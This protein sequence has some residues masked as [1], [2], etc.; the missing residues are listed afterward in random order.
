MPRIFHRLT[1]CIHRSKPPKLFPINPSIELFKLSRFE[2]MCDEIL[3]EIFEYFSIKDLYNSFVHLNFRLNLLLRDVHLGINF[4]DNDQFDIKSVNYFRKE[5][6]YLH[7]D[8]NPMINLNCFNNLR[9]LSIYLPTRNQLLAI[10]N[11]IMPK[12]TRLWIGIIQSND[13]KILY[14]NFFGENCLGK[15]RFCYLFQMNF[16]QDF[17]SFSISSNIRRLIISNIQ[18]KDILSILS[19]FPSLYQ[20]SIGINDQNEFSTNNL[21]KNLHRNLRILKIEFLENISSLNDLKILLSFVPYVEQ[22]TLL[23]VNL[24]QRKDYLFLQNII[25]EN[26]IQLKQFICSIDYQCHFSSNHMIRKFQRF[27]LKFPFFHTMRIIPCIIHQ[28]KCLRKTFMNK[29]FHSIPV[30]N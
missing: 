25:L 1:S 11:R 9:S 27:I 19:F 23:F 30:D 26:F 4:N 7:I 15:L 21:T 6:V 3:I 16:D 22:C 5:I 12:L 14:E 28:D 29:T 10:N 24:I 8:S 18:T 17:L 13:Q 20:L 2:L